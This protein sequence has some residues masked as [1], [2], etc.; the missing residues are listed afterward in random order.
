MNLTKE[1]I[2]KVEKAYQANELPYKEIFENLLGFP[3]S[4][5]LD[6][7]WDTEE[8]KFDV[9]ARQYNHIP[10]YDE[11]YTECGYIDCGWD[12]NLYFENDV[13]YDE[14]KDDNYFTENDQRI[15]S[16]DFQEYFFENKMW[17]EDLG[18]VDAI[19]EKELQRMIDEEKY[20]Y[21]D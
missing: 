19:F 1:T 11:K 4:W 2:E 7:L 8:N 15:Y 14:E 17:L 21:E 3:E 18:G 12:I 6:I 10:N 13:I 9:N 20:K 5:K 16:E